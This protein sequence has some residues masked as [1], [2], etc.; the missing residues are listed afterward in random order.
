MRKGIIACSCEQVASPGP[1]IS[2]SSSSCP[3][4]RNSPH[5]CR[6]PPHRAAHPAR[7]CPCAVPET[8][9]LLAGRRGSSRCTHSFQRSVASKKKKGNRGVSV[10]QSADAS[11]EKAGRSEYKP[12]SREQAPHWSSMYLAPAFKGSTNSYNRKNLDKVER[13]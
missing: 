7:L 13:S 8:F 10:S 3:S 5:P 6:W 11:T 12:I 1:G 9:L 4:T 2:F